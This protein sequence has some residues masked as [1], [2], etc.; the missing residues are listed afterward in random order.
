MEEQEL[1]TSDLAIG[2]GYCMKPRRR[3]QRL[4]DHLLAS[5]P[6]KAEPHWAHA[7]TVI[8]TTYRLDP[9]AAPGCPGSL[10]PTHTLHE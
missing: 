6:A 7:G 2:N 9:P 4:S 8:S 1:F 10:R 5:A 3:K